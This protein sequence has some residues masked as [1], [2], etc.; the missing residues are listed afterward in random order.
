M[1]A[2]VV[3]LAV[4]AAACA[5]EAADDTRQE[6]TDPNFRVAFMADPHVIGDDYD[7]CEG[8]PLDTQT[9]YRTRRRFAAVKDAVNEVVPAAEFGLV[10]GDVMHDAYGPGMVDMDVYRDPAVG[11]AAY[12]AKQILD[13]FVMPVNL[14]WGNHDYK[15]PE[16][17]KDFSHK[18]F[19]EVFETEP[20][21][22]VDHGGWKFLFL[23]TQLGKTWDPMDAFFGT[24]SGS[25]GREQMAWMA[26]QLDEGKPTVLL[27]HHHPLAK[28]LA[29]AEDPDGPY[30]DLFAVVEA[31]RD[32]I[33]GAFFGHLHIWSD[34]GSFFDIPAFVVG[35]IRYDADN[36]WMI[37]FER[38][39]DGWEIADFDKAGFGS[40]YSYGA[41]YSDKGVFVDYATPVDED[42]AGPWSEEWDNAQA[43]WPPEDE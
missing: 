25:L 18:L 1:R 33:A 20:Y 5:P 34:V 7:C 22:A 24:S 16:V 21:Y 3:S 11:S 19:R 38:D 35:S 23:N 31:Y 27:M 9:I 42:P 10:L 2:L 12:H 17:P 8:S 36:Y 39:G 32:T 14:L 4:S 37:D 15:V 30:A 29:E 43:W 13:D 41:D 6:A 40:S 28:T 26:E